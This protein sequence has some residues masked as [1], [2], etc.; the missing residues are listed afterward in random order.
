MNEIA[1]LLEDI[2]ADLVETGARNRLIHVNREAK[3]GQYINVVNE[4]SDEIF[5]IIRSN[6]KKMWFKALGTED[7]PDDGVFFDDNQEEIEESRF[8]DQFL[9]CLLTPNALQKRLLGIA[10]EA[11]T[12]EEEQGINIL[13][14]ALGFLQWYED[15]KSNVLRESPLI[16]VPVK[17]ERNKRTSTYELVARD[18]DIT[19]NLSLHERLNNDF[20]I[21]LP[22]IEDSDEW[23]PSEYFEKINQVITD[24]RWSIDENGM[25][26]GFFSFGKLLMLIDLKPENWE[27]DTL[28]NHPIIK[29]L[30]SEGFPV[31]PPFFSDHEKLDKVLQP[32]DILQVVDADSSQTKVIEAVRS[33][34]NLVVQGP[35][36]TGKSQTITNILSAAAYDGKKVLFVAE[37]MAA[38]EVVRDRLDKVGLKDLYIELH[39]RKANKK[40]F[41]TALS[42]TLKNSKY[43]TS[44]EID[45]EQITRVRDSLNEIDN[46]LHTPVEGRSYTPYQVLSKMIDFVG[47]EVP[48]PQINCEQMEELSAKEEQKICDILRELTN[49]HD[50]SGNFSEHPFFGTTNLELQPV[51]LERLK[52]AL[53]GTI[54]AIEDWQTQNES[55]ARVLRVEVS[56]SPCEEQAQLKLL[57]HFENVPDIGERIWRLVLAKAEDQRFHEAVNM[58]DRWIAAKTEFDSTV[59]AALWSS[60]LSDIRKALAKGAV[61]RIY[62][63]FPRYRA[64]SAEF[65]S[66]LKEA[67]PKK[68]AERLE[69]L[70]SLID[71]QLKKQDF[72]NE[73]KFLEDTLGREW[74]HERTP[75]REY[76][77]CADWISEYSEILSNHSVESIF[78]IQNDVKSHEAARKSEALSANVQKQMA[79]VQSYLKS[80]SL[81]TVDFNTL[82]LLELKEDFSTLINNL[83][84]Y[85]EWVRYAT[86]RKSLETM[87]L[88]EL[89]NLIDSGSIKISNAYDEF[90]YSL[91]EAR[92]NLLRSRSEFHNIFSLSRIDRHDLVEEYKNYE[93]SY[94]QKMQTMIRSRHL[95]KLPKG[96]VG[97]MGIIRG[98]I[99]KKTRFK[100][101]RKM[102]LTA[103]ETIQRIKPIFLMSPISVAQYLPPEKLTFDLLVIDEASQVRPADALGSIAR[104]KQIVVVGDQKQLPPTSFFD[105][106]TDNEERE[107][108]EDEDA[109][110]LT[111]ATEMES[112]L[113][114]CEARGI[115]QA[116]LQWHY[117]SRDPSLI[118]VSNCEFYDNRLIIPP[119]P[120]DSGNFLGLVL[121]RVSGVYSS[122]SRGGGRRGTNKIEA[123]AVADRLAQLVRETNGL[124]FGIVTFSQAQKDMMTEVLELK[125]RHD[126]TLDN[127]LRDEIQEPV[128]IKNIENVQGDERDVILISVGYGP[129]EA[130]GRLTSMRFGP[131]NSE[132]GERRLNVLF[133]RARNACEVFTSFDPADIN[134][135]RST[136][137]GPRVLKMFLEYAKTGRL[138]LEIE[139]NTSEVEADSEFEKDVAREISR[140]GYSVEYQ[141]GTAG[142]RIDLGVRSKEVAGRYILAVEC[143]GAT[144]HSALWARERDR[145]R[146]EVLEH[147]GWKFHR[148]WSTDWY[149]R[150]ADEIKRLSEVLDNSAALNLHQYDSG[151]RT[152]RNTPQQTIEPLPTV[153]E[154]SKSEA[155]DLPE[156]SYGVPPYIKSEISITSNAEPHE[157][158]IFVVAD[159]VTQIIEIEGLVHIDEIARRYANAHGKTRVGKRILELVNRG[160]RRALLNGS[161]LSKRDFWGTKEQFEN[162]PVRDRSNESQSLTK[163]EYLPDAEILECVKMVRSENGKV[164]QDE[165]IREIARVLGFKRAGPDFQRRVSAIL[166]NNSEFSELD[167]I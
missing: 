66:L 49:L 27:N 42:N 92:M 54:S 101:I 45:A 143:D 162:P 72:D 51:D 23:Q 151:N 59:S 134:L 164:E 16:L 125:R 133:T 140:L 43:A 75:F 4:R 50:K 15:E 149:Y 11:S 118:A 104:V 46:I 126:S 1:K 40:L 65:G 142:F 14:L 12:A 128:F 154:D 127:A 74:R 32:E 47:R 28:V 52:V 105:R 122:G 86:N 37:K 57:R 22:E 109:P 33:G 13:Y 114:L 71:A 113:S 123:E 117:R 116:M 60:N 34:R 99:G 6:K 93:N 97:E 100:S 62:R 58:A 146:Q 135:E 70:D 131:V 119:S 5:K 103:G 167:I 138:P 165:L 39:S 80:D 24:D 108:D 102:I 25:Q 67:V 82:N 77:Q 150:K 53:Q 68:P 30:L 124:S 84:R 166:D 3:R 2:Q 94:L 90:S 91:Y 35:P 89:L 26:F 9:E 19:M 38:L 98:E 156:F 107:E 61:S 81:E 44:T 87:G 55:I 130:D 152:Q 69:L 163:A 78:E 115:N 7:E 73:S 21:T 36:G 157:V 79:N 85:P 96:A 160:A 106:L 63:L 10:N 139:G 111:K 145:H 48:A 159:A 132:G 148:I 136:K 20:G 137:H 112:I 110:P 120:I 155:V 153:V 31:E 144:Y 121:K 141:V 129:H 88:T 18:D 8:T 41:I 17:L 95:E 161:I 29:G 56:V 147:F 76:S 83:S 64:V 158:D